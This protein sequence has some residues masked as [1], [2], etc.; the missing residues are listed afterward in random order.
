MPMEEG[1]VLAITGTNGKTT[2]TGLLG[3]IMK[4]F[5]DSSYVV[6]NIGKPY[7]EAVMNMT[8]DTVTVAEVS[9]FQLETIVNFHQK[10]AQF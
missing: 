4:H 2:T 9:S 8:Q 10:S 7:T 3:A 1:D 5:K 6:G